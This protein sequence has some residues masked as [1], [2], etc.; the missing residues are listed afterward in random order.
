M[1][2]RSNTNGE[3][4]VSRRRKSQEEEERVE[5]LWL[6]KKG[7]KIKSRTAR[8]VSFEL[9]HSPFE[10]KATRGVSFPCFLFS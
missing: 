9:L 7:K 3:E 2:E 4:G 5:I 6:E 1:I 8:N 10:Y